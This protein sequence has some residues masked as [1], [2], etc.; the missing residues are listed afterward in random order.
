MKAGQTEL[1]VDTK[2]VVKN[3]NVNNI[4]EQ[5][6]NLYTIDES[7]INHKISEIIDANLGRR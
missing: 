1:D 5:K 4:K 2:V 3:P 7:A 6:T